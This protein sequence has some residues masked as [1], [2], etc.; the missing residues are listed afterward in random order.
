M[1]ASRR[2]ESCGSA[3]DEDQRYCLTCGERAGTRSGL[4]SEMISRT[5]RGEPK[6]RPGASRPDP[7]Q[8]GAEADTAAGGAGGWPLRLPSPMI[9][10]LLVA[11]F[12]GF[13]ALLGRE[14][15]DA[16]RLSAA[17][18]PLK[19]VVHHTAAKT[20]VAESAGST[21]EPPESSPEPT[22]EAEEP[23]SE[24]KTTTT[25]S[26]KTETE[27]ES[28]S[29][30]KETSTAKASLSEIKH[31]F[32]IVLSDEPYA[33]DFGPEA[34]D[35]YLASTLEKKGLL[36][37]HYDAIAH[38]GLADG[39]ALL[40][41]QGPTAQT[42]ANCPTYEPVSPG[43][44][45]SSGQATGAGCVYPK[46]V[47]TLP[48]E[49]TAKHLSWR[50]FIQG[51]DEG[52]S[53]PP[54]CAHPATGAVDATA[55]SGAFA[56]AADPF[57]YFES[58]LQSPLCNEDVVGLSSL[59]S[60]LKGPAKATPSFSYI[61]PDRCEDGGP[62][63]CSPG[64]ATGPGDLDPFLEKVVPEILASKA[65]KTN[66]LLVITT[67]EAPA[68]GPFADSSSCCGQ[69]AYPNYTASTFSHGG[70]TVGA[71]LLSPLL[72][73]PGTAYQEP[74]NHFELLKTFEDVF[75]VSHLGYAALPAVKSL[76]ASL[77]KAAKG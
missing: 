51:Q 39:V 61:V 62:V 63:A 57:V 12:V 37:S 52:G 11:L 2:C 48:G 7:V 30:E 44:I 35:H 60:A 66:G 6:T 38:E 18:R 73:E 55:S 36:L 54:A 76:S 71:L 46:A 27:A 67:D 45:G 64:A 58:I 72:A 69:P 10:A 26:S 32:L 65:Y 43:T 33:S 15:S 68:T 9:S 25:S 16:G 19:L 4:L 3:L 49:L 22:P 24:A 13:G 1:D 29:A 40:S 75:G 20:P 5:R 59:A 28:K 21:T 17:S 70:G 41:G 74:A 31:V 47:N 53:T 14:G 56:T 42:A 23:S 50:A 77:L 8:P 34:K